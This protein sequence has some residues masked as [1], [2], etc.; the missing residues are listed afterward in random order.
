LSLV[1]ERAKNPLLH[2]AGI[3]RNS[4]PKDAGI[5]VPAVSSTS[6]DSSP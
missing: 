3:G 4:G 6:P 2:H 1:R 5:D